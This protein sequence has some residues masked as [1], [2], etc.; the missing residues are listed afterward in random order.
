MP[1]VKS[2]QIRVPKVGELIASV[3]RK[4]IITGQLTEEDGLPSEAVLM[5]EF[6]VS[7]PTLREAFRILESES[8]IDIRR[9]ARG[10]ARVLAPDGAIAAKH[11]GV[12]LQFRDTKVDDVYRARSILELPLGTIVAK[13]HRPETTARLRSALA[14]AEGALDNPSEYLAHE[15]K[16]HLLVAELAGNETV[17]TIVE[18]LYHILVSARRLYSEEVDEKVIGMKQHEVHRTHSYFTALIER[19]DA[20]TAI[21]LWARH[22]DEIEKHYLARPLANTVVEILARDEHGV[23]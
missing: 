6:G 2:A 7:R 20:D 8:L 14:E 10:G 5:A 21:A 4:Q 16:F 3:L 15:A 1:S 22:L 12:L 23:D 13:D 17:R 19:R 11:I 9:G 18:I